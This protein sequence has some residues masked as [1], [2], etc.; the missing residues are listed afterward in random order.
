MP[1]MK[2]GKNLRRRAAHLKRAVRKIQ[3]RSH[4]YRPHS[5]EGPCEQAQRPNKLKHAPLNVRLKPCLR[6]EGVAQADL[7]H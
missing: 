1:L 4:W 3:I 2:S 5:G 6:W 7:R